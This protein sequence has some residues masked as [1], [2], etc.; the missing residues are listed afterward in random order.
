[1]ITNLR[2]LVT[3]ITDASQ[4]VAST[5]YQIAQVAGQTGQATSQ[6]AQAMQQVANGAQEQSQQLVV[7][8]Q[9]LTTVLQQSETMQHESMEILKQSISVIAGQVRNLGTRSAEIGL[10]VKTIDEIAEQTT[11]SIIISQDSIILE[12]SPS[13]I[14]KSQVIFTKRKRNLRL[15]S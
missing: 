9:E 5:F 8:S 4:N 12:L 7:A 2:T 14:R 6:V 13:L 3:A 15:P 11:L 1:M 10:I